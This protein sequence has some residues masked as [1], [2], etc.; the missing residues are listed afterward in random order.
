MS[1][2]KKHWPMKA[3]QSPRFPF[4]F[5]APEVRRRF[6]RCA[7]L[8]ST[9]SLLRLPI[10][11]HLPVVIHFVWNTTSTS[12]FLLQ[13]FLAFYFVH[14]SQSNLIETSFYLR[15]ACALRAQE[16]RWHRLQLIR[17]LRRTLP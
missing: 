11:L 15:D 4:T 13:H 2:G 17:L 8:S 3:R 6:A 5:G 10:F 1:L 9:H 14:A 7:S 12:E 16:G